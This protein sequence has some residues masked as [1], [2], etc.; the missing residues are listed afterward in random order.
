LLGARGL[1]VTGQR[2]LILLELARLRA[3]VSHAELTERLAGAALDRVTIYRNLLSLTRAGLLVKAQLGDKVW[4]FSLPRA[5]RVGHGTH[6]HFICNECGSVACL[7]S[8]SVVLQ[9]NG[10]DRVAEIQLRG[11][12]SAC[13]RA[14]SASL[15][16]RRNG[17][18]TE[19]HQRVPDDGTARDQ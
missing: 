16:G 1:R 18:A 3:P 2:L 7:P 8:S 14:G 9:G 10:V 11:I 6:P 4:R 5:T 12:C 17:R 13:I 19:R 15:A